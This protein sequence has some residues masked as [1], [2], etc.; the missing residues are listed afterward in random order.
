M[1]CLV[2]VGALEL[3]KVLR[4]VEC[5]RILGKVLRVSLVMCYNVVGESFRI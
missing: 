4:D 1:E 2:E 3:V 5:G